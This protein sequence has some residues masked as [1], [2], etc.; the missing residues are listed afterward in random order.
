LDVY[1]QML[2]QEAAMLSKVQITGES[3]S[4]LDDD[5]CSIA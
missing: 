2:S 4:G 5:R 1:L 3:P